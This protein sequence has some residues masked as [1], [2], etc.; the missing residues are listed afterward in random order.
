MTKKPIAAERFVQIATEL[1]DLRARY[2]LTVAQRRKIR[3]LL[4]THF[5]PDNGCYR[6]GYSDQRIGREAN[7]TWNLV[8]RIRELGWAEVTAPSAPH[9]DG[10]ISLLNLAERQR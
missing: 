1:R 5:D 6:D 3:E 7:V 9:P 10:Q 2:E 8:H 4:N